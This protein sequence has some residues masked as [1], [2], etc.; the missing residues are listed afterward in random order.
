M[1]GSGAPGPWLWLWVL[2]VVGDFH[3]ND[4]EKAR[5]IALDTAPRPVVIVIEAFPG[6]TRKSE[7]R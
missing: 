2:P 5:F 4:A 7:G 1:R 3:L 6:V